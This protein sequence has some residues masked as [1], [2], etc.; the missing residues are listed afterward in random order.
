MVVHA[1]VL[2][3]SLGL[4]YFGAEWLVRGAASIAAH[5][6]VK[7]LVVGLVI[8]GFGTSMPEVVVSALA[9][10]HGHSETALGNVIGSNIANPGLILAVA[11]LI[12]SMK[13]DLGLLRR[14]GPFM[15]LISMAVWAVAWTGSYG[16]VFGVVCLLLLG[17]FVIFT[18]R[19]ASAE[20]G[21][22]ETEFAEYQKSEEISPKGSVTRQVMLVAAGIALL[23]A[24]GH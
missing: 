15:V 22:L 13:S 6:G 18:L 23:L 5:F 17:L 9:S 11:T 20:H 16:R 12:R 2:A 8:V 19:W 21:K 3:G 14:E 4:L 7:P 24:G 1:A 10:L